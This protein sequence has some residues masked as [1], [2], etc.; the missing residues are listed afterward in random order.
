MGRRKKKGKGAPAPPGGLP[1]PPLPGGLPL[2]PGDAPLPLSPAPDEGAKVLPPAP[3]PP[4]I[5][6]PPGEA[7]DSNDD[8]EY[9]RIWERRSEKP[10]QQV[11]GHIDRLGS[12]EVGSLLDRYADR[13]GH[14][15]DREIIVLRGKALSDAEEAVRDAPSVKLLDEDGEEDESADEEVDE[16]ETVAEISVSESQLS[17]DE[18]EELNS[19]LNTLEEEI[20]RLKPKYQMAKK[21]GQSSKLKKL[22]PALKS[23]MDERKTIMAVLAGEA[24][25]DS[26]VS[27]PAD[28]DELF[29]QFV[30]IVDELLGKMPEDSVADFIASEDFALYQEVASAPADAAEDSQVDFFNLVDSKLGQM[31][32][33]AISNFVAS[34]DFAIYQEMGAQVR[35]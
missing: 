17:T 31:P 33:E 35:G 24:S 34:D 12:G 25:I 32:E 23:L 18:E 5:P 9:S 10:L 4:G 20:R 15:L 16:E 6:A 7:E 2:P 28:A 22:K 29:L 21:K 8:E 1:L 14:E 13:F 19:Q 30:A 26:L 11:Y 27:E 3:T